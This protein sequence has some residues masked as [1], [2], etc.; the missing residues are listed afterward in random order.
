MAAAGEE[1]SEVDEVEGWVAAIGLFDLSH[2]LRL[3]LA[4]LA[5]CLAAC[6]ACL[7][8]NRS[9]VGARKGL[10][11]SAKVA[12]A[13]EAALLWTGEVTRGRR[14]SAAELG[15]LIL[16]TRA[17]PRRV[18]ERVRQYLSDSACADDNRL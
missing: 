18:S 4:C 13:L 9:A 5:A 8:W 7:S 11:V 2:I 17:G 14:N 12:E 6:S 3:L 10:T 15:A 16:A 1:G